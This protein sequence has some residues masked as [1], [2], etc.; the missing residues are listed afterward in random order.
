MAETRYSSA[1]SFAASTSHLKK[2]TPLNC[3]DRLSNVGLIVWQ[4]PHLDGADEG[5][6]NYPA[7]FDGQLR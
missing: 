4:G 1:T 5:D 2:L 6:A 7:A 3:R